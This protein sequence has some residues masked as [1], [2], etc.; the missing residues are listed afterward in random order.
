VRAES[1]AS[2]ARRVRERGADQR[3]SSKLKRA[4]E[5]WLK[6]DDGSKS[7]FS[8]PDDAMPQVRKVFGTK[9]GSRSLALHEEAINYV[10]PYVNCSPHLTALQIGRGFSKIKHQDRCDSEHVCFD[11]KASL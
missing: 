11:F 7:V 5:V 6:H 10:T 2:A 3:S 8:T 4:A 1:L 9:W